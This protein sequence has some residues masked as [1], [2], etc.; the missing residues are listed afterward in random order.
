MVI[1]GIGGSRERYN[2][3]KN[4]AGER[5]RTADLRITSAPLYRLSY[6]SL[7]TSTDKEQLAKTKQQ[8]R[9]ALL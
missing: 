5:D 6:T 7:A 2:D 3:V 4:R 1:E 8:N 9:A